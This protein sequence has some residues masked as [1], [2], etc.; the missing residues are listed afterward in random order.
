[1]YL[2]TLVLTLAATS[3]LFAQSTEPY[4]I[5]QSYPLGGNGGWDYIIPD[6]ATHRLFIARESHLMVVDEE[7]GKLIG[8]VA[9]INGAHGTAIVTKSGHGFA[10]AGEDKAVSCLI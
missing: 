2:K 4:R 7:T 1:M 9:G 8:E 6:T 3:T 5:T 10:T